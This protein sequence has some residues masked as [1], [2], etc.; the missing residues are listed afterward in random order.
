MAMLWVSAVVA[1]ASLIPPSEA[2][3]ANR[4]AAE[5]DAHHLLEQLRVPP[6]ASPSSTEPAGTS[7]VLDKS[8]GL[9]WSRLIDLT[10]WWTVPGEPDEALN[11][12]EANP[13]QESA[14]TGGGGIAT[15]GES[16]NK[17]KYAEFVW[18][19]IPGVLRLRSLLATVAAGPPGSTILRVDARVVWFVP[20]PA[21]ER[22]PASARVLEVVEHHHRGDQ[23]VTTISGPAVRKIVMLING[24][25]IFQPNGRITSVGHVVGCARVRS[26]HQM[27]LTFRARKGRPVLAEAHQELPPEYCHPMNLKIRA[28]NQ[29]PLEGSYVVI[30]ALRRMLAPRKR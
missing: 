23:T 15:F 7:S 14:L 2:E 16:S 12:I 28:R 27:Q 24:L 10:S 13:P 19:S 17:A 3:L 25:P 5:E 26:S 18:P 21:S 11:W 29:P 30:R 8:P 6:G 22:V 4:S 9:E 1:S 20:R